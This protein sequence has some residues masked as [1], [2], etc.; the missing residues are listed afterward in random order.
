LLPFGPSGIIHSDLAE[1]EPK[2]GCTRRATFRHALCKR[3]I[4]RGGALCRAI[5]EE[6][7]LDFE[8]FYVLRKAKLTQRG[9]WANSRSNLNYGVPMIRLLF[10]LSVFGLGSNSLAF[11]R[12]KCAEAVANRIAFNW[13]MKDI[14]H[15]AR[16]LSIELEQEGPFEGF[17]G[18]SD[19]QK[20]K[21]GEDEVSFVAHVDEQG[22]FGIDRYA[23]D[24]KTC[25]INRMTSLYSE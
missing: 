21:L 25:R 22:G 16:I 6:I 15:S 17:T 4:R 19:D 11:D 14:A 20:L 7:A 1:G 5:S 24:K 12:A 9:Q 23:L 13:A 3:Y 18:F 8:P 10:A 2:K